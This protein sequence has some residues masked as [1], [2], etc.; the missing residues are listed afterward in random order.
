MAAS[1]S[2][3]S[4][5]PSR[6]PTARITTP[7]DPPRPAGTPPVDSPV[8][9]QQPADHAAAPLPALATSR[10]ASQAARDPVPNSEPD[11]A[12]TKSSP[13]VL[14]SLADVTATAL[15]PTLSDADLFPGY[16]FDPPEV[17][18][19]VLAAR[20][21]LPPVVR[22]RFPE[23]KP[24]PGGLRPLHA[25]KVVPV[26]KCKRSAPPP[27][28]APTPV[29]PEPTS[30]THAV[31][32]LRAP[33]KP[34]IQKRRAVAPTPRTAPPAPSPDSDAS[35]RAAA[36]ASL[37]ASIQ[38]LRAHKPPSPTRA[39]SP[40]PLSAL[41]AT[42]ATPGLHRRLQSNQIFLRESQ[43]AL[44][45]KQTARDTRWAAIRAN[46]AAE[47][48][49]LR[50]LP[51]VPAAPAAP[52]PLT[53]LPPA[54]VDS[55]VLPDLDEEWNDPVVPAS[56]IATVDV[57][58]IR[59]HYIPLPRRR[60]TPRTTANLD[61]AGLPD[62]AT[63]P[64]LHASPPPA[65]LTSAR[66]AC[67]LAVTN[68]GTN[69]VRVH[70]HPVDVV[71][72][73]HV[74]VEPQVRTLFTGQTLA[75]PVAV[76]G[77]P[78]SET[79]RAAVVVQVDD[80]QYVWR[81]NVEP[82]RFE[83]ECSVD[84]VVP[85]LGP[86]GAVVC[87]ENAG[88]TSGT[89][90][91]SW[92]HPNLFA[93]DLNSIMVEPHGKAAFRVFAETNETTGWP[94]GACIQLSS[95]GAVWHSIRV[96]P[97]APSTT[98]RPDSA[99]TLTP[100]MHDLG[101]LPL[102]RPATHTL[103]LRNRKS[104]AVRFSATASGTHAR[105][106]PSSGFVQRLA[107]HP[108]A[109]HLTGTVAGPFDATVTVRGNGVP[110]MTAKVG[111]TWYDPAFEAR[112][113][114]DLWNNVEVGSEVMAMIR[115]TN[116]S[117]VA[118]DVQ[119]R[120]ENAIS[121][122]SA[123]GKAAE[124]DPD[125][126]GISSDDDDNVPHIDPHT[127][128]I[129]AHASA[130]TRILVR[131]P[132]N[133]GAWR[134]TV[135]VTSRDH[136]VRITLH[137]HATAPVVKITPH[138]LVLPPAS[139]SFRATGAFDLVWAA[140]NR[141]VH[142]DLRA[143]TTHPVEATFE[144]G[145]PESIHAA[146]AAA[147]RI[148]PIRGTV[149]EG[150]HVRVHVFYSPPPPV[151]PTPAPPAAA[152]PP[153]P[154]DLAA[155]RRFS[156]LPSA[157]KPSGARRS[158]ADTDN[159]AVSA[160]STPAVQTRTDAVVRVPV[161]ITPTNGGHGNGKRAE[162]QWVTVA[163]SAVSP[164]FTLS[165]PGN[166]PAVGMGPLV[167]DVGPVPLG[168]TATATIAVISHLPRSPLDVHVRA[169]PA[170]H[171]ALM[172]A[173]RPVAPLAAGTVA[174]AVTPERDGAFTAPVE[175]F[176]ASTRARMEVRGVAYAPA[177]TVT[178]ETRL[179]NIW[180]HEALAAAIASVVNG[181]AHAVPWTV[182]DAGSGA[183][184]VRAVPPTPIPG[185]GTAQVMLDIPAT[186]TVPTAP[187]SHAV[188]VAVTGA[189]AR[190]LCV[191]WTPRT[192][193]MVLDGAPIAGP[194]AVRLVATWTRGVRGRGAKRGSDVWRLTVP[195]VQVTHVRAPAGAKVDTK[196]APVAGSFTAT[197]AAVLD[198]GAGWAL[199]PA[200]GT[201]EPGSSVDVRVVPPPPVGVEWVEVVQG[202]DGGSVYVAP[203]MRDGPP[204]LEGAVVPVAM[205][206]GFDA[207]TRKMVPDTAPK[208]WEVHVVVEVV[209]EE[210]KDGLTG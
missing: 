150:G 205:V 36:L 115:V 9:E 199:E 1:T 118:V 134:A 110:P 148:Y 152:S 208:V 69:A 130:V 198:A 182:T 50:M 58:S 158:V 98:P 31:P 197:A 95:D 169:N 120:A 5:P 46:V 137:G 133:L 17:S 85:A 52:T 196:R 171:V 138:T 141:I 203:P 86:L 117:P 192:L 206:G 43:V 100:I 30:S 168:T 11:L 61:P 101:L 140:P 53:Q 145:M 186:P 190:Q 202:V 200:T 209:D 62:L 143:T 10:P 81:V 128:H 116:P 175:L 2:R 29:P 25:G 39:K 45:A 48:A 76:V 24:S 123:R 16:S 64:H 191:T 104:H 82:D 21:L 174:L 59:Q 47:F 111:G 108:I 172:H 132:S 151:P 44:E 181:A 34:A 102:T 147:L 33:A 99:L 49:A 173:V 170:G 6:T 63:C 119:V 142:H 26:P 166:A 136:A 67:K 160:A 176:G 178:T 87:I 80:V 7:A 126:A 164:A 65:P 8:A 103:T 15:A 68:T 83:P 207:E 139:A 105:A 193:G 79:V 23:R 37:M 55:G 71:W 154:A 112:A 124:L 70:V 183:A 204:G 195:G 13:N 210:G 41:T 91:V 106:D 32:T 188:R 163:V 194:M 165:L 51:P 20:A 14:T 201:V 185:K 38:D 109:V 146:S 19:P 96:L 177:I 161:R 60:T 167:I 187:C 54:K 153:P 73:D 97:A 135:T 40:V 157:A 27:A 35:R 75:A 189:P 107:T 12:T 114:V 18:P 66:R 4:A 184:A 93:I 121:R 162:V 88:L 77:V 89:V 84:W 56:A 131:V 28:P 90:D 92:S 127:L 156:L 125:D 129:P 155:S 149:R 3:A 122:T 57:A 74:S 72:A 144:I 78:E 159:T 94:S 42:P 179:G 22:A 113:A 180:A